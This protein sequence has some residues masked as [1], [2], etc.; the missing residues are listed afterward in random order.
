M[1][2]SVEKKEAEIIKAGK[3]SSTE[4]EISLDNVKSLFRGIWA[5]ELYSGQLLPVGGSSLSQKMTKKLELDFEVFDVNNFTREKIDKVYEHNKEF[6][7]KWFNEINC[8]FDQSLYH[9]FYQVQQKVDKLLQANKNSEQSNFGRSKAY[10]DHLPKLS[11]LVGVSACAER[12]ALCQYILQK[13]SVSSSCVSGIVMENPD[14]VNEEPENHS[15]VVCKYGEN[16]EATIIFDVARPHMINDEN[17]PSIAL[18]DVPLTFELLSNKEDLLV[19]ASDVLNQ[20]RF[21]VGVG[22]DSMGYRKK[23]ISNHINKI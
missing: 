7:A 23:T 17:F 21:W 2:G 4:K 15:F 18:T 22:R 9:L 20:D 13:I 16:S 8:D 6:Y 19:G 10:E 5:D 11:E 14:D 3:L 12:A 1:F